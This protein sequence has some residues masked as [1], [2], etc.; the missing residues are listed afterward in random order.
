MDNFTIA[1]K[2][3]STLHIFGG[4]WSSDNFPKCKIDCAGK[5]KTSSPNKRNKEPSLET[6][7]LRK[8]QIINTSLSKRSSEHWILLSAIDNGDHVG[9]LVWDCLGTPLCY[10]D[11]FCGRL[12]KL[13]GKCE[14]FQAIN[15]PLQKLHS[16]LCGL[17]CLQLVHFLVRKPFNVY[18]LQ[19]NSH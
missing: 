13:Y 14:R 11:Q 8:F 18:E 19:K 15:L 12:W 16:N 10:Y 9:I 5:Q 3:S 6:S 4:V 2:F 17:C 1:T 7:Q